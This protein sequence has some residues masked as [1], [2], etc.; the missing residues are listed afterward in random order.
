MHYYLGLEVWH[1][2]SEIFLG[3]GK[4][5][6]NIMWKLRMMDCKSLTTPIVTNIRKLRDSESYLVDPSMYWKL[7]G[8]LMYLCNTKPTIF[9]IVNTFNQFQ[10][11]PIHDHWIVAKHVLRYLCGIVDYSGLRYV[12][13][14]DIQVQGYTNADGTGKT[15]RVHPKVALVWASP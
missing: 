15:E 9:F 8:S 6:I 11:E 14:S 13:N 4:Y 2:P 3:Q 10:M 1:N 5:I 7:I 12:S